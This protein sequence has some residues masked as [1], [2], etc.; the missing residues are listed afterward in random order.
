MKI[1]CGTFLIGWRWNLFGKS[2]KI[3]GIYSILAAF[4]STASA[5]G[6]PVFFDG[7]AMAKDKTESRPWVAP[8]YSSQEGRIG[9]GKNP[10]VVTEG[11]KD[12]VGFWVDIYSKYDSNQG[13]LHDSEEITLIYEVLDLPTMESTGLSRA[14]VE[15]LRGKKVE[16]GKE[17]VRAR[18]MALQERM[19]QGKS[20]QGLSKVD[21]RIWQRFAKSPSRHRFS[22]AARKDRLRLQLGQKD[23]FLRGIYYSGWY[24][25]EI[26]KIFE[27]HNLP[28][29]LT[30]LPLV[31]SSFNIMAQSKVGA[32]GLW[33]FMR[34]TARSYMKMDRHVDERNDPIVA[35]RAAAKKFK[36]IYNMI[37][38][39]P[40]AVTGYNYGPSGIRRLSQ[41]YNSRDIAYLIDHAQHS[42]FGFASKNFYASFLAALEVEKSADKYFDKPMRSVSLGSARV[43]L[44]KAVMWKDVLGWFDGDE[45][46]ARVYNPHFSSRVRSGHLPIPGGYEV[47]VPEA[48]EMQ[49]A[50]ALKKMPARATASAKA[51]LYKVRKG[52]TLSHIATKFGVGL[53][54][55][56]SHNDI[57]YANRIRAGQLIEIPE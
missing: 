47:H 5:S 57:R 50:A 4:S 1:K 46:R 12:R 40:L 23:Q 33:Q 20:E 38:S 53:R 37:E 44:P 45:Q 56:M 7:F 41:K 6:T 35:T 14:E 19:D 27:E 21:W 49:I 28:K 8:D 52:E 55:L 29:E 24:I 15:R 3:A 31:E 2:I 13:V 43:K 16:E 18:L 34:Y 17:R 10:F 25:D 48:K 11:M 9:Y 54:A 39:W 22:E 26:E 30:R 36:W 32:S 51:S 42:R